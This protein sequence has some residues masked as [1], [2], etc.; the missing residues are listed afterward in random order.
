M[1][2]VKDMDKFR[3]G[4]ESWI[5]VVEQPKS[6]TSVAIG[7]VNRSRAGYSTRVKRTKNN[8]YISAST[9]SDE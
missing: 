3:G 4:V 8:I 6:S 9:P 2:N 7:A 1:G 5:L